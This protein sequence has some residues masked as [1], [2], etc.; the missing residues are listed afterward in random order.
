M[1]PKELLG[2]RVLDDNGVPLGF[3]K[4]IHQL[5]MRGEFE[6]VTIENGKGIIFAR[7]DELRPSGGQ[8]VLANGFHT[9]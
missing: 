4:G 1:G 7:I 3:I 5:S 6:E 2:K 9:G 8:F